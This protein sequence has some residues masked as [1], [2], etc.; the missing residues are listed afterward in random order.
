MHA[1]VKIF[2]Q[3]WKARLNQ[4]HNHRHN[5][6]I[7]NKINSDRQRFLNTIQPIMKWNI[8]F[9]FIIQTY[10][11]ITKISRYSSSSIGIDKTL[12]IFSKYIVVSQSIPIKCLK[13]Q[14][15]IKK[16]LWKKQTTNNMVDILTN[17]WLLPQ[18][19]KIIKQNKIFID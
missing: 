7:F 14:Y 6:F 17:T 1:P 8:A 15:F 13:N 9:V 16:C 12:C 5:I 3:I 11:Y 18:H 4:G 2:S 19:L 10:L